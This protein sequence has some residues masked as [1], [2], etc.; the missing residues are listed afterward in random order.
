MIRS[1]NGLWHQRARL[2]PSLAAAQPSSTP[3]KLSGSAMSAV[4][5][6]STVWCSP[7]CER[8]RYSPHSKVTISASTP[9]SA[10]S[11]W[12]SSAMRLAFGL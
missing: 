7:A 6:S 1:S 2:V 9:T 4:Q 10:Q 11:A 12:I 3:R 8:F 5:P